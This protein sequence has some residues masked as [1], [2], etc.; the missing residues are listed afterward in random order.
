[1]TRQEYKDKAKKYFSSEFVDKVTFPY[2][3]DQMAVYFFV[4]GFSG[5][6]SDM[7]SETRKRIEELQK[8]GQTD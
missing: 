7:V 1:M 2:L 6:Q 5:N 4:N 8:T 3:L